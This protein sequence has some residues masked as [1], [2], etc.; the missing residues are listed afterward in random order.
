MGV[1]ERAGDKTTDASHINGIQ[2]LIIEV[3]FGAA[4]LAA[5]SSWLYILGRIFVAE[6][7]VLSVRAPPS[8]QTALLPRWAFCAG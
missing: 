3:A 1:V 7:I 5:M 2:E 4:A 6:S 8:G